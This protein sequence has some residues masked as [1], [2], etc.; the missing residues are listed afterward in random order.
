MLSYRVE[1]EFY[2]GRLKVMK[3]ILYLLLPLFFTLGIQLSAMEQDLSLIEK[4]DTTCW[5]TLMPEEILAVI[6]SYLNYPQENSQA[7][8]QHNRCGKCIVNEINRK[9]IIKIKDTEFDVKI[10]SAKFH[11][12]NCQAYGLTQ[13]GQ[14]IWLARVT[15]LLPLYIYTVEN[16]QNNVG[17]FIQ[18]W[19]PTFSGEHKTIKSISPD[20]FKII[21]NCTSSN[22][23]VLNKK[24]TQY[25]YDTRSPTNSPVKIVVGSQE[26]NTIIFN[27]YSDKIAVKF[28][29][30]SV[31]IF[32]IMHNDQGHAV[33][34]KLYQPNLQEIFRNM[35]VC[36]DLKNSLPSDLT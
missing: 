32:K 10:T 27:K 26:I 22:Y 21:F 19:L 7:W 33:G 9:N 8:D 36:K 25:L 20:L 6:A 16:L 11:F 35:L 3:K 1:L 14:Y 23:L 5:L 2:K 15:S 4:K 17:P 28:Q 30:G 31:R 29:D 13:D 24:S 34:V 12:Q 18:M